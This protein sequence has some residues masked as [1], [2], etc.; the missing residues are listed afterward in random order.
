MFLNIYDVNN[1][2]CLSHP[3]SVASICTWGDEEYHT[4]SRLQ[5]QDAEKEHKAPPQEFRCN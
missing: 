4:G 1:R 3:K 2:N 5:Q